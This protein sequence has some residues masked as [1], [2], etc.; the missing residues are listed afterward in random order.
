MHWPLFQDGQIR[1]PV[2]FLADDGAR[3]ADKSLGWAED[4]TEGAFLDKAKSSTLWSNSLQR[5]QTMGGGLRL[6]ARR[7]G[8]RVLVEDSVVQQPPF[9]TAPTSLSHNQPGVR[10]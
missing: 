6:K 4:A 1:V 8:C 7:V 5:E 9:S 10:H 3:P 2:D